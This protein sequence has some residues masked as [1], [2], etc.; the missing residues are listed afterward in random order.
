MRIPA[1]TIHGA[2]WRAFTARRDVKLGAWAI[3]LGAMQAL[4]LADAA[5]GTR[6]VVGAGL[7]L[8]AMAGV[9]AATVWFLRVM[10]PVAPRALGIAATALLYGAV[11][12]RFGESAPAILA[13]AIIWACW[14]PRDATTRRACPRCADR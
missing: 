2:R 11:A 9:V 4:L 10:I 1:A 8:A 13:P 12:I 7:A 3:T 5:P 6:A 14:L